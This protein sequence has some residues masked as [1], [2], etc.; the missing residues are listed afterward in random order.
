MQHVKY[1]VM[2]RGKGLI[3][4][5]LGDVHRRQVILNLFSKFHVRHEVFSFYGTII[6]VHELFYVFAA[7]NDGISQPTTTTRKMSVVVKCYGWVCQFEL[8]R[9]NESPSQGILIKTLY[10]VQLYNL[11][12]WYQ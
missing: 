3:I 5:L 2:V 1:S 7:Y 4:G 8:C 10:N 9:F 12:P 11:I 6:C